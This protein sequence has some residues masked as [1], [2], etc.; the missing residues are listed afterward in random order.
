MYILKCQIDYLYLAL[1]DSSSSIDYMQ[2][3]GYDMTWHSHLLCRD[4]ATLAY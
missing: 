4:V 3:M 2:A 1:S